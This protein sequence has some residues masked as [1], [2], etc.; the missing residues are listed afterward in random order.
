MAKAK[1]TQKTQTPKPEVANLQPRQESPGKLEAYRA[2]M[3]N[4][5][6]IGP[7]EM[8]KLIRAAAPTIADGTVSGWPCHWAHGRN[9]PKGA[10]SVV[11]PKVDKKPKAD[12]TR[13]AK[14][15]KQR[16]RSAKAKA[17]KAEAPAAEQA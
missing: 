6:K 11:K 9:L 10:E 15:A 7:Q 5:G 12:A 16:E 13:E 1:K 3:A 8:A 2:W 17:A 14:N 4:K